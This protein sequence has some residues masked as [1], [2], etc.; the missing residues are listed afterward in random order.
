VHVYMQAQLIDM[1][2]CWLVGHDS[3]LWKSTQMSK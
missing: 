1:L 2:L 3:E